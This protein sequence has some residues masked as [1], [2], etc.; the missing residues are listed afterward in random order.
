M[1]GVGPA[2]LVAAVSLLLC[3]T[4]AMLSMCLAV[5][6]GRAAVAGLM[7]VANAGT[8][9][10]VAIATV[11]V[12]LRAC[13]VVVVVVVVVGRAAMVGLIRPV[14][15]GRAA[16]RGAIAVVRLMARARR[17]ATVFVTTGGGGRGGQEVFRVVAEPGPAPRRA[18]QV[19][20]A[21]VLYAVRAVR[22]HGHAADGVDVCHGQML[23]RLST[24]ISSSTTRGRSSPSSRAASATQWSR[25]RFR[26]CSPSAFRAAR[27]AEIWVSTSMQ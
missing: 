16:A 4:T 19:G 21:A 26:T 13:R 9:S 24:A 14:T 3:R 25:C 11:R 6:V 27:T 15:D 18:E 22:R 20:G 1:P 17:V 23:V 12:M 2:V 7:P 10:R 8:A 5:V